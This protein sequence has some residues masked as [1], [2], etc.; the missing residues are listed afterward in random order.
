MTFTPVTMSTIVGNYKLAL[1]DMNGDYLDDIVSVS[2]TNI[3]VHQQDL[4]GNFTIANYTTFPSSVFTGMGMAIGDLNEDG[5]NDL[6]CGSGSGVTFMLSANGGTAFN[7]VSD[8][9]TF[10]RNAVIWLISTMTDTLVHLCVA[11]LL[12]TFTTSMT[13]QAILR[14][15]RR[16]GRSSNGG[17]YGSM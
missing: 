13:V 8:R 1:T 6:L 15:I 11:M 10:F 14:I 7:Q 5:F 3:Q 12:Q 17:N 4:S 16:F 9:N 2:D